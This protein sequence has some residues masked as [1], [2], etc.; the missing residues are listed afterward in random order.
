V[1]PGDFIETLERRGPVEGLPPEPV[2]PHVVVGYVGG[3]I[4]RRRNPDA[5]YDE[6]D[7]YLVRRPPDQRLRL[8]VRRE[9]VPVPPYCA[10]GREDTLYDLPDPV[11]EIVWEEG[12]D[13][14]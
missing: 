11:R 4:D 12:G 8:L 10:W 6:V 2:H 1:K 13:A 5:G 9:W 3:F 14:A 7:V